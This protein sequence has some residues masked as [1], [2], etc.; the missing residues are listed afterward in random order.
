MLNGFQNEAKIDAEIN[1]C[2]KKEAQK[3]AKIIKI[4]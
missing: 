3:H 2:R 1:E 4:S